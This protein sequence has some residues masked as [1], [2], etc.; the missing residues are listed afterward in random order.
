MLGAWIAFTYFGLVRE[1]VHTHVDNLMVGRTTTSNFM[2]YMI[3]IGIFVG[4]M[5]IDSITFL[6]VKNDS[7]RPPPG[8]KSLDVP[9]NLQCIATYDIWH[10]WSLSAILGAGIGSYIGLV[11]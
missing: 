1:H 11:Y 8:D 10:T 2:Y 7:F 4:M 9:S 5:T 6:I 3:S